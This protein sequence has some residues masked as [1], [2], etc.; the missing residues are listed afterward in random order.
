MRKEA[1]LAMFTCVMAAFASFAR[2]MQNNNIYESS[3]GLAVPSVWSSVMIAVCVVAIIGLIFLT[4]RLKSFN[5][6]TEYRTALRART[7]MFPIAA[8]VLGVGMA[9]GALMLIRNRDNIMYPHLNLILAVFAIL[10]GASFPVLA[11]GPKKDGSDVLVCLCAA[12]PVL[13]FCYWL[14]ISYRENSTDPVLW[15]FAFEILALCGATLGFY[16]LAGYAFRRVKPLHTVF[17][18]QL[19]AFLCTVVLG[20][21]RIMGKQVFFLMS[22]IMLLMQSTVLVAR[23]TKETRT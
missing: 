21:N 2:W 3:T 6:G 16:Y 18:T 17:F 22:G 23:M 19:G 13:F 15:A 20:D 1:S 11:L 10:C 4:Y 5:A 14:V 9:V 12:I 8:I 7:I